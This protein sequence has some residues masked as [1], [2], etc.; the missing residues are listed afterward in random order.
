[1][2]GSPGVHRGGVDA[3]TGCERGTQ[4]FRVAYGPEAP[5]CCQ[6][7][8]TRMGGVG[9]RVKIR[10]LGARAGPGFLSRMLFTIEIRAVAR[11]SMC[12]CQGKQGPGLGRE[13]PRGGLL[14]KTQSFT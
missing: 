8:F 5:L 4:R 2:W 10:L 6:Q 14:L 7:A 1:M 3:A 13:A 12:A 11:L 9:A